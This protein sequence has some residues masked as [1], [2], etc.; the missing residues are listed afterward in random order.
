LELVVCIDANLYASHHYNCFLFSRYRFN[1][2]EIMYADEYQKLAMEFRTPTAN[3]AYALFNLG[4]EAGEVLGK[5]AKY[6]RDGGDEGVLRQEIKKE[7]GDVMWMVAAVGADFEL[8][9]SEICTHNL[10]KLHS[11]KDREVIGGSGDNR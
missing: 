5:V 4:A 11:R 8:T 10:A 1:W 7:L 3:E 9:L 6:I 2:K